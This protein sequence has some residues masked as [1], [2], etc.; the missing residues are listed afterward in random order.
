MTSNLPDDLP[1]RHL[2]DLPLPVSELP[3]SAQFVMQSIEVLPVYLLDGTVLSL[4]PPH[5]AS[6]QVGWPQGAQPEVVAAR[7]IE[8]I[9]LDPVVL[10][11][12][13][14]RHSD[15]EVVLTYLAVVSTEYRLLA[16]WVA[17]PVTRVALARGS[18]TGP[19]PAIGGAQ[20]LEHALRHLAWLLQDD[21]V[22]KSA[23]PEWVDALYDY[24]PEP[25]QALNSPFT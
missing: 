1:S 23:L 19:P 6:F 20:V 8:A 21:P 24:V 2:E 9:G 18:E 12:T 13:S 7:A 4:K 16:P 17:V 15:N 22:I 10:H 14:W 3:W 11:S 5:A 25:F